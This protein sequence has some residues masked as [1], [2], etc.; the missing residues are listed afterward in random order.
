M[1]DS[2]RW[3]KSRAWREFQKTHLDSNGNGLLLRYSGKSGQERFFAS[4]LAARKKAIGKFPEAFFIDEIIFPSVV[5]IAQTSSSMTALYKKGLVSVGNVGA[6]ITG[7]F[8]IDTFFLSKSFD[9]Y[10]H[11]E[12]NEALA[13]IVRHNFKVMEFAHVEVL[14]DD[15]ELWLKK[16]VAPLDFIMVDP[17]RRQQGRRVFALSDCTPNI[18][19]V[20]NL[21]SHK[22]NH[23][24]VKVSPMLDITAL[25]A[26]LP[27]FQK[28][29]VLEMNGD[30]RELLMEKL[31]N[32]DKPL[33]IQVARFENSVWT[34][35]IMP[36]VTDQKCLY[37]APSGYLYE[38]FPAVMKSGLYDQFALK[39]KLNKI[40]PDTHLYFS[41]AYMSEFPGKIYQIQKNIAIKK[42][43][44]PKTLHRIVSRNFPLSSDQIRKKFRVDYGGNEVLF[45]CKFFGESYQ[46][47]LGVD[48]NL[49]DGIVEM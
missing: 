45:V 2:R 18:E 29:H 46:G 26:A 27:A 34:K 25:S 43:F 47:V 35:W 30:C 22:A 44:I 36:K 40:H 24:L 31:P 13:E 1:D 38:P 32:V 4:Q 12:R 21:Y 5:S 11:I 28:C 7:G 23:W 3:I 15:A 41:E 8:G 6:D 33:T 16:R 9:T 17:D 48:L 42:A 39:F 49:S 20:A 10:F 14:H 37:G 19:E